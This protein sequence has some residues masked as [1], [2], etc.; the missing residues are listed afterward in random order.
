M[1]GSH[2]PAIGPVCPA[3]AR[4][5]KS[6]P[7]H[8]LAANV[9]APK[10][11]RPLSYSAKHLK[12]RNTPDTNCWHDTARKPPPVRELVDFT[13][14]R[15]LID[16]TACNDRPILYVSTA[17]E[18]S[19]QSEK[20]SGRVAFCLTTT[21][22]KLLLCFPVTDSRPPRFPLC[23]PSP[24]QN[25]HAALIG[26]VPNHFKPTV[27]RESPEARSKSARPT[28]VLPP[29]LRR[30]RQSHASQQATPR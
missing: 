21:W 26:Q 2:Q 8:G 25:V 30:L 7:S 13:S 9:F 6:A 4:P 20:L 3:Q 19:T 23:Q 11:S 1:L 17:P 22:G 24:L 27:V 29:T 15:T 5:G 14:L 28:L 12:G 16:T 10:H 18:K